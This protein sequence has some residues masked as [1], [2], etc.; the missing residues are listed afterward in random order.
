[1]RRMGLPS[2]RPWWYTGRMGS[3]RN[4]Q[5]RVRVLVLTD[6][7]LFNLGVRN[8]LGQQEVL[9]VLSCESDADEIRHH[10]Q[11]FQPHV[12]IFDSDQQHGATTPEWM[13]ILRDMPGI[14][15]LGLSLQDNSICI[16]H[17][18]TQQVREVEDLVRA[19]EGAAA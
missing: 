19:I 9:G 2:L 4:G 17:G 6:E 14:R 8:L 15:L 5:A 13:W 12:V 11:T 16:Y 18:E 10:L 7:S 1:M 3:K